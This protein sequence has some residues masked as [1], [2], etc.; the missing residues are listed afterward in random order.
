[1]NEELSNNNKFFKSKVTAALNHMKYRKLKLIL[2][3]FCF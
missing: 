2:C 3:S 1:M